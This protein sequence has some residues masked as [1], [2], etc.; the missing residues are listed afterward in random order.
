LS[1]SLSQLH[2]TSGAQVWRG[3]AAATTTTGILV[4]LEISLGYGLE[5]L[6][7]LWLFLLGA[8]ALEKGVLPWLV[9]GLI[10]KLLCLSRLRCLGVAFV[11]M[12]G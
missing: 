10:P 5:F 2:K 9:I 7:G 6:L 4:W 1:L 11:P 3:T 8:L 12:V